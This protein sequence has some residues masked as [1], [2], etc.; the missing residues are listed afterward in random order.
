[1]LEGRGGGETINK[2]YYLHVSQN[3]QRCFVYIVKVRLNSNPPKCRP[4]MTENDMSETNNSGKSKPFTCF[5]LG[6]Y[7]GNRNSCF[8]PEN[9]RDNG[10]NRATTLIVG[11]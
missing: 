9:K 10:N 5:R 2:D 1:M 3:L 11:T 6:G 8:F 7:F 4:P